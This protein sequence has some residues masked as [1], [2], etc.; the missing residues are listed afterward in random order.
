MR[1]EFENN[2]FMFEMSTIEFVELESFVKKTK[3]VSLLM[4]VSY[5]T[6]FRLEF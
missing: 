2:I 5:L 1:L 6:I 3:Y 4:H